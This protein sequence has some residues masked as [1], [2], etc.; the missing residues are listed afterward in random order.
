LENTALIINS[1]TVKENAG[2]CFSERTERYPGY[3]PPCPDNRS[4]TVADLKSI[5]QMGEP[6]IVRVPGIELKLKR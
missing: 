5:V 3:Y 2:I 1:K 4:D 6:G